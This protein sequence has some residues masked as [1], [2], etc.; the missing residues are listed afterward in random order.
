M[1]FTVEKGSEK[2]SSQKLRWAKTRVYKNGHARVETRVFKMLACRKNVGGCIGR[3]R[4][5]ALKKR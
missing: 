2:G 3:H 5:G 1:G 4:V